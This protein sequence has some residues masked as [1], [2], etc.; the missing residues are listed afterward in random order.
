MGLK[1]T[2]LEMI[3]A[4]L[5]SLNLQPCN[6]IDQF[7]NNLYQ[8]HT[9]T[10]VDEFLDILDAREEGGGENLF[11][12]KNRTLALSL[13]CAQYST[14]LY[15]KYFYWLWEQRT[16]RP[17]R[18]LDIGCEN[19]IVSCFYA[20]LFPEAEVIGIDISNN[21]ISCAEELAHHL[22]LRNIRFEVCDVL[23]S[24]CLL[25]DGHFDIINS[26]CSVQEISG[27]FLETN[28]W[29]NS[30]LT[31][32][33]INSS[34]SDSVSTLIAKISRLLEDEGSKFIS[35]ERL[36]GPNQII[37]WANVLNQAGL[38]IH[39]NQ[40][41]II[42]FHEVGI[43][44]EMPI[45]VIMNVENSEEVL[46]GIEILYT[47]NELITQNIEQQYDGPRAEFVFEKIEPKKLLHGIQV[48]NTPGLEQMRLEIWQS[49]EKILHY[50]YGNQGFRALKIRPNQPQ[51][52]SKASLR[53]METLNVNH[54]CIHYD[55]VFERDELDRVETDE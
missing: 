52:A 33:A 31:S 10:V 1:S 18:I 9:E 5:D 25:N 48:N 47:K 13:D 17:K 8:K 42:K 50:H 26:L 27:Y 12:F 7:L 14:D 22:N 36:S 23:N 19:G 53:L 49:S 41:G 2:G 55:N 6:H 11:D 24:S 3:T 51:Y 30:E 54:V 20:I 35:C 40:S 15:Q 37:Y 4:Y 32:A 34:Q 29:T 43:L 46:E 38:F 28:Y 21:A 45:L 39:W 16:L 44:Q